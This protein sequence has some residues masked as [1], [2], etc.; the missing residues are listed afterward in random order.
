M[1]VCV[2]CKILCIYLTEREKEREQG[3]WQAE[4]EEEADSPLSKEPDVGPYPR[5][6]DNNLS[7]RLTLNRLRPQEPLVCC[8]AFFAK[9]ERKLNS[10]TPTMFYK[11]VFVLQYSPIL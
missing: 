3:E 2:F 7:G 1:C 6:W 11:I 8:F 4:G 9:I 5:P 10:F